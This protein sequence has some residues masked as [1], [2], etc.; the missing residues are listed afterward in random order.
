MG[1]S[2][3]AVLTAFLGPEAGSRQI[4]RGIERRLAD[5]LKQPVKFS[6]GSVTVQTAT[7]V[8]H[9][10]VLPHGKGL[11]IINLYLEVDHSDGRHANVCL[12]PHRQF[13]M[14]VVAAG[15][16]QVAHFCRGLPRDG[17]RSLSRKYGP[18]EFV[19][20]RPFLA[21][22]QMVQALYPRVEDLAEP[23]KV[24]LEQHWEELRSDA[25][26]VSIEYGERHQ[27]L[28]ECGDLPVLR[29]LSGPLA[30][31]ARRRR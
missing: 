31:A 18:P 19:G 14:A 10:F 25:E 2:P 6:A 1:M 21:L 28:K 12:Q 5:W 13:L 24:L 22:D 20:T 9:W 15:V 30:A 26:L 3:A 29:S 17:A 7:S 16:M 23:M 8:D 27:L 4:T 11:P